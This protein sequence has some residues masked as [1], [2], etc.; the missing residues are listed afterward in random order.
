MMQSKLNRPRVELSSA[1]ALS[2]G[3]ERSPIDTHQI[4]QRQ[5]QGLVVIDDTYVRG[6][7]PDLPSPSAIIIETRSQHGRLKRKPL[8]S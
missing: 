3:S 4:H 1:S 2:N 7:S 6:P 8:S 5:A